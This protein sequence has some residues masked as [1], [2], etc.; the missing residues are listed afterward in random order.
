MAN[1]LQ[2]LD[3]SIIVA[4]AAGASDLHAVSAATGGYRMRV[5]SLET[6][7]GITELETMMNSKYR[8]DRKKPG[9]IKKQTDLRNLRDLIKYPV[10]VVSVER[11]PPRKL[12]E[13]LKDRMRPASRAAA[14]SSFSGPNERLKRL[15]RELSDIVKQP[16]SGIDVYAHNDLSVWTVIIEAPN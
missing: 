10:D 11:F 9:L 16:I 14:R 2:K 13:K 3:D 12:N 4:D 15:M 1:R 5:D 6:S 7:L 8:P